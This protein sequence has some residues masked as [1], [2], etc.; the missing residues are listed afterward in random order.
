[1]RASRLI[2]L[3][4]SE[5]EPSIPIFTTIE[6]AG[7]DEKQD[8]GR[9]TPKTP[10]NMFGILVPPSLRSAQASAITMVSSVIPRLASIDAEMREVEIRI[11]RAR[12]H[13]KR[14]MAQKPTK[15]IGALRAMATRD[16]PPPPGVLREGLAPPYVEVRFA[17]EWE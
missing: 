16:D 3:A 17:E 13:H 9:P 11:R 8:A 4:P 1:M 7:T 2:Q 6:P 10:L 14:E 15:D 5:K 12:K